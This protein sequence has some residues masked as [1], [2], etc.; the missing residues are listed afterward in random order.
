MGS[1][2]VRQRE[3]LPDASRVGGAQALDPGREGVFPCKNLKTFWG[4]S[5]KPLD[6]P[7]SESL[8]IQP[9]SSQGVCVCVCVVFPTG[10]SD[11][12]SLEL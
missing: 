8:K 6:F 7:T 3:Q 9:N 12:G 1:R 11:S 2:A 10:V 5:G 4:F